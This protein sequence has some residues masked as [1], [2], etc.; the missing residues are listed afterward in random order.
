VTAGQLDAHAYYR[1]VTDIDI[2]EIA[3]ELLAGRITQE[4]G[5]AGAAV[6]AATSSS[7]SNSSMMAS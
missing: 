4:S 5:F 2:G 7:L 1:Q 3:R 6:L